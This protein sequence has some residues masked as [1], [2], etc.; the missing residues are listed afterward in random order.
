VAFAQSPLRLVDTQQRSDRS[1]SRVYDTT[2]ILLRHRPPAFFRFRSK[3]STEILP[4]RMRCRNPPNRSL[5][6]LSESASSNRPHRAA[7]A[8]PVDTPCWAG[9]APAEPG[10]PLPPFAPCGPAALNRPSA[11]AVWP[12]L[13]SR[14]E[15]AIM[16]MKTTGRV[17]FPPRYAPE[18]PGNCRTCSKSNFERF[19]VSG[20][21]R[22]DLNQD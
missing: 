18:F 17:S 15:S 4:H 3:P 9:Q 13:P 11:Q 1:P 12:Q 7:L 5:P 6:L 14:S 20:S 10:G 21:I 22:I 16:P 8:G 2:R 19:F